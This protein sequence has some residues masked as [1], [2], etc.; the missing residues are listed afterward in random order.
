[1]LLITS[2]YKNIENMTSMVLVA[3]DQVPLSCYDTS[4]D[5]IALIKAFRPFADWLL[6]FKGN[7][8]FTCLRINIQNIDWIGSRIEGVKA[9]MEVRTHSGIKLKQ[10]IYASSSGMLLPTACILPVIVLQEQQY[11]LL[12]H[13]LSLANLS[14]NTLSPLYGTV[15]ASGEI[16]FNDWEALAGAGVH[17]SRQT[18]ESLIKDDQPYHCSTDGSMENVKFFIWRGTSSN[19]SPKQFPLATAN[20]TYSLVKMSDIELLLFGPASKKG[21]L[22]IRDTNLILAILL[23]KKLQSKQQERAPRSM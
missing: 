11:V 12:C 16:Q 19:V 13:R 4:T 22:N 8:E 3:G 6:S 20:A 23:L 18:L 10:S 5:T 2:L 1:V 14:I 21:G 9:E 17:I 7:K 15:A